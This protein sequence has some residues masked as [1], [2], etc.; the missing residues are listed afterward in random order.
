MAIESGDM[1]AMVFL[2]CYY[3]KISDF[4]NALEYYLMMFKYDP[5]YDPKYGL[6][7]SLEYVQKIT[8]RA[9]QKITKFYSNS[10][11][12]HI[13]DERFFVYL[14]FGKYEIVSIF[15]SI[16]NMY[17]HVMNILISHFEYLPGADGFRKARYEFEKK[18]NNDEGFL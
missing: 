18:G 12:Y 14:S 11:F 1:D 15:R 4:D 5:V 3:E 10:N 7:Y 9:Y 2:A 8:K 16:K 6:G 13:F 17:G